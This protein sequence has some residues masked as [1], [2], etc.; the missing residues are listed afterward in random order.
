MKQHSLSIFKYYNYNRLAEI[1]YDAGREIAELNS[2]FDNNIEEKYGKL[3]GGDAALQTFHIDYGDPD[4][5][6]D[7]MWLTEYFE[8]L[9]ESMGSELDFNEFKH[10]LKY[11]FIR[12]A[13][14]QV[15]PPHTASYVRAMCSVNIPMRGKT[16]I[17]LYED[18][19]ENPH[20]AGKHI[21][22]HH[23]TSPILLHVN[24]FHGVIN[25]CDETRMVLKVHLPVVPYFK[26]VHSFYEP[27]NIFNFDMPWTYDRGTPHRI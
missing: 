19:E 15:L 25:D 20:K 5:M 22:K 3:N 27:V 24:Q 4:E 23:Y 1:N 18:H 12:M 2:F 13:P 9:M 21:A 17:D 6:E 10:T 7:W 26:L 16:V 8:N 11:D 14:H